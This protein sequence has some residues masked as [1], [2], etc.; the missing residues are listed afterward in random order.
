M[1]EYP[2]SQKEN[3]KNEMFVT[4]TNQEREAFSEE[5]VM[6][7]VKYCW[8]DKNVTDPKIKLVFSLTKVTVVLVKEQCL[9]K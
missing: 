4:Y 3:Q 9:K 2:G 8:E 6:K 5:N 1:N 7:F